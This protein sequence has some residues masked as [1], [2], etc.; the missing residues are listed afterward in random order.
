VG[1]LNR[2]LAPQEKDAEDAA[3]PAV[4]TGV[5]KIA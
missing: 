4:A 5:V 2:K 1:W 3:E